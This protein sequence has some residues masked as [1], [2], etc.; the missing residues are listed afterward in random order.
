MNTSKN[1]RTEVWAKLIL[2]TKDAERIREL[3]VTD[4][5]VKPHRIVEKMHIT[6]YHAR[7]PLAR[8]M[9][10]IEKANVVLAA[11]DTRFMVMAPG[12]EN[13]RPEHDPTKSTIG[14]RIHRQSFTIMT[15]LS[16][17]RRMLAFETPYILGNRNPST[18]KK[19]AFGARAYQPHMSVLRPGN[20]ISQDLKIIG[21][22]FR[23]SMGELTFDTF[24]VEIVEK[25]SY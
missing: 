10:I 24:V 9:P 4:F 18:E 8:L 3:F 23:E 15:I 21:Q 19:S 1:H 17:R 14:I 2:S 25:T 13:P 7:R 20:R 16:Y 5:G 11:G 12:G 22:R 6:I